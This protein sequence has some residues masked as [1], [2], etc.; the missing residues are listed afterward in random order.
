MTKEKILDEVYMVVLPNDEGVVY[1]IG[2]SVK[3]VWDKLMASE[4]LGTRESLFLKGYRA[5]KVTISL[6]E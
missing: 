5:K 2:N 6:E 1:K 3:E 4:F